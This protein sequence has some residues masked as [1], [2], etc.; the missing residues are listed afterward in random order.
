MVVEKSRD[1]SEPP[2]LITCEGLEYPAISRPLPIIHGRALFKLKIS[3]VGLSRCKISLVHIY[4]WLRFVLNK[5]RSYIWLSG[6]HR[7]EHT[8][9]CLSC[10]AVGSRV[11]NGLLQQC[12][13]LVEAATG[14]FFSMVACTCKTDHCNCLWHVSIMPSSAW[15]HFEGLFGMIFFSY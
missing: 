14:M 13:S 10:L 2:L 4:S 9:I 8:I 1:D 6:C 12:D 3:Q 11:L 15:R 5:K 7:M